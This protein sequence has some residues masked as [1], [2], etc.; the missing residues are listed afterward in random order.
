[1][2]R[3]PKPDGRKGPQRETSLRRRAPYRDPQPPV[4]IVCGARVTEPSYLKGLLRDVDNRSAKV[5]IMICGKDPVTVVRY[6]MA[7]RA[8]AGG[9]YEQTW[10]VLDVDDFTHLDEALGIAQREGIEVA[11]SNPCFETWLLLHFCDHRS[12]I[13]GYRQAKQLLLPHHPGYSKAAREFDFARYRDGWRDATA[14]ARS[15]AE[16]GT[17]AKVNPSSGMWR[18][19]EH[20]TP[21]HTRP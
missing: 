4:L 16:K 20:I 6:A 3:A 10:C 11:L 17:E 18:L 15:L 8:R 14:H 2:A 12:S 21:S 13:A 19:L 5:K 9:H 7:Q 1:V